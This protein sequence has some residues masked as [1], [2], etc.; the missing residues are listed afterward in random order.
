M[1]DTGARLIVEPNFFNF[2]RDMLEELGAQYLDQIGIRMLE[3]VDDAIV[4]DI[5][6]S[7]LGSPVEG[8]IDLGDY[9]TSFTSELAKDEIEIGSTDLRAV[10]IEFGTTPA[11]NSNLKDSEVIGWAKRKGIGGRHFVRV[12]QRIARSIRRNG[13]APKPALDRAVD[14]TVGDNEEVVNRTIQS[15]I[16][17]FK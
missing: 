1:P 6:I 10:D 14:R 4:N 7:K 13:I 8:I 9:R 15:M 12:G 16:S 5:F 17:L 11:Q 2:L 3:N